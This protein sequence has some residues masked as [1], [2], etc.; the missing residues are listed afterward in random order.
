M[1]DF[2]LKKIEK[3]KEVVKLRETLAG[4]KEKVLFINLFTD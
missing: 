2:D 3:E 4:L 1:T